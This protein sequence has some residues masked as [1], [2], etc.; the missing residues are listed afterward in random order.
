MTDVNLKLTDV[1][2]TFGSGERIVRVLNGITLELHG[3]QS[4]AVMGPSGSGKSTLLHLIGTLDQPTSG[5]I[6]INGKNPFALAEPDLANFRNQGIGFVFQDHHLLPQYSVLENV[7]L[8]ALAFKRNNSD[9]R[10]RALSLL[11]RVG[12]Q[13]RIDHYPA[14]LSGGESQR[15]AVARAL[16]NEPS[17]VLCD[18]P[19]GNLD[20]AN[21]ESVASLLFELHKQE[22]TLLICVT[23]SQELADHFQQCFELREGNLLQVS[24]P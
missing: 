12:L 20:H 6:E 4:L 24:P 5:T 9:P 21:A 3:G 18:E 7:M 2:K 17:I 13:H 10:S 1:H 16:M 22:N 8:P 14:Q 11:E 19:T 15:T 23:H